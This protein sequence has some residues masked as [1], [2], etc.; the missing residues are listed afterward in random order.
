M[1]LRRS[2]RSAALGIL[3]ALA[4][5]AP[6][7]VRLS[8]MEVVPNYSPGEFAHAGAGRDLRVDVLGNPFDAAQDA[9]AR[10]VTD[11]MQ[12][13]H[14][15]PRTNFTT[16]PG[17]EARESYNVIMLF[18]PPADLNSLRLCRED[19]AALPR[20]TAG[21]GITLFAAFCRGSR[22]LTSVK[23]HIDGASGAGDPAFRE[24]VGQVT[25][26]LFPPDRGIGRDRGDS[27]WFWP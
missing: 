5:C 20:D 19:P 12:G 6:G 3:A 8:Q 16:E 9:F 14:W 21:E 13:R 26:A 7:N 18:D 2:A 4:A 17:P 10:A 24:L 22:S 27:R 25:N 1:R 23:G 11:A 15:G